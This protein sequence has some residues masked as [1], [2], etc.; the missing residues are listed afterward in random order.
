[1]PDSPHMSNDRAQAING[2]LVDAWFIRAGI[3]AGP[4]PDLSRVTLAE[5]RAASEIVAAMNPRHNDDGTRTF[6]VQVDP[7]QMPELY[8]WASATSA[9]DRIYR[10]Q[11]H[12]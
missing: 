7:D 2:M 12:I 3:L 1:M 11:S 8:A 6:T 5:C 4:V 9:L 10:E